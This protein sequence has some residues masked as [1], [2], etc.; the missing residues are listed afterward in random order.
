[1]IAYFKK[2]WSKKIKVIQLK[3]YFINI[4]DWLNKFVFGN[5]F[6]KTIIILHKKNLNSFTNAKF[7]R[8]FGR[9]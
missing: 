4:T 5:F 7:S 8:F 3:F 9:P 6:G 1:M 2:H